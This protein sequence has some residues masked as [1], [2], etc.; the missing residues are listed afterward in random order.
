MEEAGAPPVRGGAG[1]NGGAGGGAAGKAGAGGMGGSAGGGVYVAPGDGDTWQFT[2][3]DPLNSTPPVL[4][5]IDGGV[6]IAGS[7]AD[8]ATTGLTAFDSGITSE[9]FIARLGHDGKAKW[10]T[11]LRAAGFPWNVVPAANDYIVVAPYLPEMAQVAPYYVS[12]DIFLAKVTPEGDVVMEKT[13]DFEHEETIFYAT[14]VAP[15]GDIFLAGLAMDIP[16]D[17]PIEQN[18]ILAKCDGGGTLLWEK[19]FPNTGHQA[20]ANSLVVLPDGDLLATGAFD[21]E[22][23]FGGDTE[24]LKSSTTLEGLVSGFLVR[25]TASGEPVW[26]E[27]FGGD[28]LTVGTSLALMPGSD[29]FFLTGAVAMDLTLGGLSLPSVPFTPDDNQPFPPS[30]AF[31]ARMKASGE[32][33]WVERQLDSEWGN[34]VVT[35]GATVF[36]GGSVETKADATDGAVYLTSYAAND[37]SAGPLYGAPSGDGVSSAALVLSDDALW[38]SGRFAGGIDFGAGTAFTDSDAGVFLVRLPKSP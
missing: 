18:V 23:D 35:D 13:L 2:S 19:T 37:G 20:Y 24:P 34:V 32:G 8:P 17:G 15:N 30:H 29:D 6:V 22:L 26:S 5:P 16:E 27:Q 12:Q 25:F 14:A 31:V 10:S 7:S 38:V 33:V 4:A 28:E 11:P 36:V 21:A 1:G 3:G 9:A